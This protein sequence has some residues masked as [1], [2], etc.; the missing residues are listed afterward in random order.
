MKEN[1]IF[2][3]GKKVKRLLSN[4]ETINYKDN[5][6]IGF[7]DVG[8]VGE[9]PDPWLENSN[10]IKTLLR[11]EPR[12]NASSSPNIIT[13]DYALS[14]KKEVRPFYVYQGNNSHGS[15]LYQQNFEYVDEHF[16]TLK[17]IGPQ[18]LASTWHQR[19]Q[20]VKTDTVD[21]KT[22]DEVLFEIPS[23]HTFDFLK[24]DAQG[25]EF[26]ILLGSTDFLEKHCLGLQLELFEVPVYKGIKLKKDVVE[27]LK[28]KGFKLVK[29]FPPH[30][31]FD[32]AHDCVFLLENH[33]PN[34]NRKMEFLK[35][36][37]VL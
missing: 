32:C 15:S 23:N 24:I 4:K 6:F 5:G 36:I 29:E 33:D 8:A 26:E 12:E 1:Y 17:K 18:T 11:F 28:E 13:M 3:L 31:T 30:G 20:L 25:A 14:S 10:H 34:K 27:F 2:K 35:K 19:A 16:E 9:L 21:C 37:Y 22:L 7:I